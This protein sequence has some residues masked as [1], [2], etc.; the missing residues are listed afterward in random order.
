MLLSD[1]SLRC[2]R[3]L[4]WMLRELWSCMVVNSSVVIIRVMDIPLVPKR[5][6]PTL[7]RIIFFAYATAIL[8][9]SLPPLTSLL[10]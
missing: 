5:T 10:Q 2:S 6:L 4:L 7:S 8:M 9:M 3:L 1:F